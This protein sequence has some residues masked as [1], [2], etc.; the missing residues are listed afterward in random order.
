MTIIW[1]MVPKIWSEADRIFLSFWT[2]FALLPPNNPKNQH[3]EK[4][5]KAPGDIITLHMCTINDNH[6]MY[7]SWDIQRDGQILLSFWTI[8]CP[9]KNLDKMKK[10]C[11]DTIILHNCIKN[12]GDKVYCSWDMARDGCNC[13]FSFFALLAP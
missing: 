9:F 13:Y 2:V 7:G 4:K 8:F 3:F 1:W 12:H 5:K 6:M 10:N 11:G